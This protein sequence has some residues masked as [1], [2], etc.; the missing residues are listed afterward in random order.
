[1]VLAQERRDA[2]LRALLPSGAATV[3]DLADGLGVSEMT[4]RRDLGIL[5][6]QQLVEKVHGGAVLARRGAA[7]PHFATK[8]GINA[9]AKAAIAEAAVA[10]V[11]DGMTVAL[12]A[13]TTTWQVA[14]RLR[15]GAVRD[16]TFVTNSLNVAGALEANDWHAIVVSGGSFRTPS[17]ALVGPFANQTLRQLNA[18]LLVLGVHSIDARA[19]LT[20]PNIAEAETNRVMVAGARRVVVVADS[21]KL[22]QVS[23]ATFA[24]CDDVDELLTDTGADQA[25]LDALT[26][27]GLRV[28]LAEP[29]P[30]RP[31]AEGAAS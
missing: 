15:G 10:M 31:P 16:L 29:Q 14:R 24:G 17:D 7:E 23:L 30:L 20:T 28:R 1:M 22:G 11:S 21:S 2:I 12:S 6:G 8:R 25:T 5:A 3:A 19:G 13:G 18:D 27:T 9:A 26:A 4:I